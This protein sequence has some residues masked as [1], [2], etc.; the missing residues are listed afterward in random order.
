MTRKRKVRDVRGKEKGSIRRSVIV[1]AVLL[2]AVA[3][4]CNQTGTGLHR[5]QEAGIREVR[6]IAAVVA[7]LLN[8]YMDAR[9]TE[10]MVCSKTGEQ[11]RSAL[12]DPEARP[13][14]NGTLE[15]WLKTSGSYEGI[16][17]LDKTGACVASAP[18]GLVN[19]DF[20][21]DSAFRGAMAG[22]VTL[23]DA[24]KS[25][26]L[27]SLDPKS[28]GWTAAIAVPINI[29]KDSAGVLMSY[30]KWSRLNELTNDVRVGKTGY[31]YV[32]DRKNRVILHPSE[33]FYGIGLRD[34]QINLPALDDAVKRKDPHTRY[35]FKNR[36]TG[37]VAHKLVGF[38]HPKGYGNVPGLAWTVAAAGDEIELA[39]EPPFWDRLFR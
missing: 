2:L 1:I 12:T 3:A 16:M 8:V 38:A 21:D 35:E 6:K 26:A 22:K 11:F 31:V 17:L 23:S 33:Q 27:V 9:V 18:T 39:G 13:N 29:G 25:D 4:G 36:M 19:K 37:T 20:S 30:L 10:M 24:H 5:S 34:P 28:K 15:E 14:A 7:D 32:L